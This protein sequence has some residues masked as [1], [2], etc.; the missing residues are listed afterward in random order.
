[1]NEELQ[2]ELVYVIFDVATG[3]AR[4]LHNSSNPES[5]RWNLE[6]GQVAVRVANSYGWEDLILGINTAYNDEDLIHG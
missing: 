5:I 2:V 4:K 1:M 6:P 3:K